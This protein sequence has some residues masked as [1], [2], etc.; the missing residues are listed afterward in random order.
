VTFCPAEVVMVKPAVDTVPT[1][2][3]A[4]PA[5]GPDRALDPPPPA[6]LPGLADAAGAVEDEPVPEDDAAQPA[7]SPSTPHITAAGTIQPRFLSGR[8]RRIDGWRTCLSRAGEATVSWW[9]VGSSS[10]MVALL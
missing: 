3:D 8:K 2:P 5:A 7:V 1:V 10:Y 9:M 6:A 4:P